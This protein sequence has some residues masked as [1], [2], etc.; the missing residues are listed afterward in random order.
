MYSPATTMSSPARSSRRDF[1]R[2]TAITVAGLATAAPGA[3]AS[4]PKDWLAAPIETDPDSGAEIYPLTDDPRPTDAIYGEQPYAN[5]QG[6]RIAIRHYAANGRDGGLSILDLSDGSLH[7]VVTKE[8]RFPAFHAWGD[9]LYYQEMTGDRLM[10]RRCHYQTLAKEDVIELPQQEGRFSYGTVSPDLRYYAASVHPDNGG[11]KVLVIDLKTGE[12][13]ILAQ[14]TEYHFKHEQFSRDVR[15]RVLIQANKLPD[16][17]EV[18]LGALEVDR[19]GIRW[20]PADRPHTPRP[21]GHEA[22]IGDTDRI[23][24]ST[25][26]DKDSRGNVWTAGLEDSSPRLAGA[27]P[28]RFG[29][30][31]VSRCGAFWIGD[32]TGEKD[33]PIHIGSLASGKHRRAVFSRTKHDRKQWSHTH[34][35]LTADNRWLIFN[36]TRSGVAQV[37]GA[38]IPER[39]LTGL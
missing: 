21:T 30:V 7:A 13:R 32:A 29:H 6:N 5:R 24:F 35:Y 27:T 11:S 26:T 10:L 38:R 34:P 18:H 20:F 17:K 19:E 8:P 37:Y 15:N 12:R 31:S 9:Y 2:F 14:R 36:S 28:V 3:N 4:D 25:A 39:F 22:W 1:L 16:V 33:I 23:L